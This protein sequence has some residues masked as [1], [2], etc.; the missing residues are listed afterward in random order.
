MQSLPAQPCALCGAASR[1][2]VWCDACDT[3]LPVL[4]EMHCPICALPT[5]DG[6]TCGRCLR[7][8]PLYDRTVAAF[9]YAFPVD[10]LIQS[11][12]FNEHLHLAPALAASMERL[13][14]KRP[15]C[16]VP[17][18]LHPARLAE[19]GHNQSLEIARHLASRLQLPL[20]PHACVRL[21]DT[22][23]QSSLKWKAR[24]RNLRGAFRCDADLTGLHVA[25]VDDVMTSGASLNELALALRRAGARE[26]SAWVAAR[27][28]PHDGSWPGHG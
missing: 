2:G 21:R 27:T 16:M 20:L 8:R 3:A 15:D 22:P 18:P 5:P 1:A 25:V 28:L 10:K 13:I 14:G 4:P 17:M 7:K 9:A 19:R 24:G 11:L 26:V 12:K 23:P 6:A